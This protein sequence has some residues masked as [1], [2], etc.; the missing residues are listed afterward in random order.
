MPMRI[1][2][3]P[4]AA[5]TNGPASRAAPRASADFRS[6]RRGVKRIFADPQLMHR[7]GAVELTALGVIVAVIVDR[8]DR[9]GRGRLRFQP[10][11]DGLVGPGDDR[12]GIPSDRRGAEPGLEPGLAIL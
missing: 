4:R 8:V 6:A 1:G 2:C 11:A 9:G 10:D 12:A 3:S 5:M 7:P